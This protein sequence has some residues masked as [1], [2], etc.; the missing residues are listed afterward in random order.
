MFII[1]KPLQALIIA[2]GVLLFFK[3]LFF[4]ANFLENLGGGKSKSKS[5]EKKEVKKEEIKTQKIEDSTAKNIASAKEVSNEKKDTKSSSKGTLDNYLYDRFVVEPT[6]EDKIFCE[7]KIN[8]AFLT[9]ND[10]DAIKQKKVKIRVT[11]V[12]VELEKSK[13]IEEILSTAET[14]QKLLDE[15]SS[16]SKEMKLMML[17]NII[18][19][20]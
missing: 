4:I 19:R 12:D 15:F 11:P 16:M 17:E 1:E 13:R 2:L 5:A 20:M 14:R 3:I 9:Q 7:N 6:K 8:D 10:V 18:K